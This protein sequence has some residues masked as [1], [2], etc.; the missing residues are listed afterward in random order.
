M[1]TKK[2]KA[3]EKSQRAFTCVY[4]KAS[5]SRAIKLGQRH[6]IEFE[7]VAFRGPKVRFKRLVIVVFLVINLFHLLPLKT[8]LSFLEKLAVKFL[9]V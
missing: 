3:R 5:C 1:N 2:Q 4:T 7:L 6:R 8:L 9:S